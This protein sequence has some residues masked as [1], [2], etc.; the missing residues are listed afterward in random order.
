MACEGRE[1]PGRRGLRRARLARRDG[2]GGSGSG[3]GAR[4]EGR[5]SCRFILWMWPLYPGRPAFLSC[6]RTPRAARLGSGRPS[7]AGPGTLRRQAGARLRQPALV[8]AS[9]P[10]ATPVLPALAV[11]AAAA[12]A[13]R[14]GRDWSG[15]PEAREAKR[16]LDGRPLA[17]AQARPSFV[18]RRSCRATAPAALKGGGISPALHAQARASRGAGTRDLSEWLISVPVLD[19]FC[20]RGRFY[21]PASSMARLII[22]IDRYRYRYRYRYR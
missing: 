17:V 10:V 2:A 16:M 9:W 21:F 5:P 14:S 1:E 22:Y 8:P 7:K 20:S 12:A 11:K 18:T 13:M 19:G 6:A 4:G 15:A 3:G